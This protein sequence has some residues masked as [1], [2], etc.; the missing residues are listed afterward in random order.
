[1]GIF[2]DLSKAYDV[3]DH[4]IL[5]FKLVAYGIRGLV[6]Q[7]F[8]SYLCNQKQYIEINYLENTSQISEKFTST[9]KETKGGVRQGL[10]LGPVLFLLYIKDLPLT[11]KEE[12]QPCL[13]MIRIY[14]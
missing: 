7:W 11:Y 3:L 2:F 6:N 10:V 9:L 4:K 5:L 14:R 12:E 13:L 8:K 1:V